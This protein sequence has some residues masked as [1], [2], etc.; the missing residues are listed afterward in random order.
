MDMG[1]LAGA[2]AMR[3]AQGINAPRDDSLV[4]VWKNGEA[5]FDKLAEAVHRV[6][7]LADVLCGAG[8]RDAS[9][10][11]E[12]QHGGMGVV[13]RIALH[14]TWESVALHDIHME[15]HRIEAKLGTNVIPEPPQTFVRG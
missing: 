11:A 8:P 3:G 7:M 9:G 10:G 15:L 13:D 14:F 4:A 5:N 12:K 2:G 1:T 6:R